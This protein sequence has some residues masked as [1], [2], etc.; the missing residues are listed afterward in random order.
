MTIENS[1]KEV[2][3]KYALSWPEEFVHAAHLLNDESVPL[4]YFSTNFEPLS[5][6]EIDKRLGM[7]H[8]PDDYRNLDPSLGLLPFGMEANGNLYC[9][10]THGQKSTSSPV[11]LL[12]NDEDED[13]YLA[14]DFSAFLFAD[15]L[16]SVAE[17]Y[18]DEQRLAEGDPQHN[19]GQWLETH[20]PYLT[21]EQTR[22]LED[23]FTRPLI[24]RADESLGFLEYDEAEELID[25]TLNDPQ[26]DEPLVLWR[27]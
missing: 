22:V 11:V 3:A 26:R 4:L 25:E 7:M 5:A 16:S 9:F 19:A 8:E 2:A 24:Q 6:Q 13:E 21:E 17:F 18:E 1:L 15:M 12:I 20:R 14:K 23:V 27:R 10:L